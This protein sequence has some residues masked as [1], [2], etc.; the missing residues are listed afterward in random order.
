MLVR[1]SE[2][3]GI[4]ENIKQLYTFLASNYNTGD[5]IYLFGYSRGA[6]T[7]RSLA[8]MIAYSGLLQRNQLAKVHDA[9]EAYRAKKSV[10]DVLPGARAVNITFIGCFDTVGSLGIP[11][12]FSNWAMRRYIQVH[13]IC[14]KLCSLRVL[15][16]VSSADIPCPM[17][18]VR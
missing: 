15:R 12:W 4:E 18:C 1:V 13:E 6:F 8:G 3:Y 17:P 2:G 10:S 11:D 7:V 14:R 16:T 9:F 5:E